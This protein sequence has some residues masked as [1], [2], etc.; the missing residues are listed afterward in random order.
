MSSGWA[1]VASGTYP[2][3][4]AEIARRVKDA[5]GWR[6]VRCDAP[7]S[8]EG[9]RILTVHHLNGDKSD[10]RWWNLLALCQ[11]CHL[12]IQGRVNP[13]RPWVMFPHTLWFRPYV[14]GFYASKYLGQELDRVEVEERLG[15]LLELER[16][17]VLS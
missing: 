14:A 3:D 10:C 5:A 1:I 13:E 7:H 9:W 2:P 6:C 15:E 11:R 17:A 4:W 12:S 8:R 16:A